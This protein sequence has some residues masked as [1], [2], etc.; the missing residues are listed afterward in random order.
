MML[1]T[2]LFRLEP[3]ITVLSCAGRFTMG[4]RLKQTEAMGESLVADGARKLVLD[5]THTETVD[6]AGLGVI[7]HLSAQLEQ[8][9]G[10]F[11]ICGANERICHL[12]SVTHTDSILAHD[13]DLESSVRHLAGD[14]KDRAP[15]EG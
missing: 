14:S 5:L 11:R 1:E 13:P 2:E 10:A 7:M 6:S 3:D 8:A 15:A 4:T 9:G 12:L